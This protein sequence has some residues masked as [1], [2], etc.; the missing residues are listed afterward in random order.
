MSKFPRISEDFVQEATG[1]REIK[2]DL[3]WSHSWT[4]EGNLR[5][6]N[7]TYDP[8]TGKAWFPDG[9]V[10]TIDDYLNFMDLS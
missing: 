1:Y 7:F 9:A 8:K 3:Y 5:G 10:G 2:G 6:G 4:A